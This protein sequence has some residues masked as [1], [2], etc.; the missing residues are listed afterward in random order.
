MTVTNPSARQIL[1]ADEIDTILPDLP[2]NAQREL[3]IAGLELF[4]TIGYH[5]TSTRA[6][7][8]AAGVSD[9]A[10]YV[11]YPSKAALL[12]ELARAG[13]ATVLGA[14][15]EALANA[16]DDPRRRVLTF[17]Q[18]F[19]AWHAEHAALARVV[20]YELGA[21]VEPGRSEVRELRRELEK[22][23]RHELAAGQKA[24]AF[25][26]DE[27]DTVQLALLSLGIDVVRWWAT[28]KEKNPQ[29]LGER[30]ADL[31]DRLL[32]PPGTAVIAKAPR[33]VSVKAASNGNSTLKKAPKG[34]LR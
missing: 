4:G 23:L 29:R 12:Y 15:R 30:Y 33:A 11:H 5:G 25:V 10:L 31:I 3:L 32:G 17:V 13:H 20:Q 8:K 7:A 28:S 34:G 6:I 26:F 21:L 14:V 27:L 16:P 19:T 1:L 24:G 9:A 2:R 22:I 18:V